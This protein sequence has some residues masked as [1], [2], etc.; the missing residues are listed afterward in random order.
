MIRRRFEPLSCSLKRVHADIFM[1]AC[2]LFNEKDQGSNLLRIITWSV[3]GKQNVQAKKVYYIHKASYWCLSA[4]QGIIFQHG[5]D[6]V[7]DKNSRFL[8]RQK[9]VWFCRP[10]DN[11]THTVNLK[12]SASKKIERYPMLQNRT[13]IAPV[14][15]EEYMFG[16]HCSL[17]IRRHSLDMFKFFSVWAI[18][19]FLFCLVVVFLGGGG[20]N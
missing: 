13:K 15:T 2:T 1:L 19:L 11:I 18:F 7:T 3:L 14:Q 10:R 6:F 12:L 16:S 5:G 20:G 9:E 8:S 4:N 17:D